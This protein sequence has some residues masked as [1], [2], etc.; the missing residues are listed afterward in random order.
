LKSFS[1]VDKTTIANNVKG[2]VAEVNNLSARISR[3]WRET[4]PGP[5][6]GKNVRQQ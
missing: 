4:F 2:I 6:A 3:F 1:D 5:L